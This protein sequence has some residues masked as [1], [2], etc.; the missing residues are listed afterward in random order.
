MRV[1]RRDT[2]EL[3]GGSWLLAVDSF[4]DIDTLAP[5]LALCRPNLLTSNTLIR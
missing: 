4:I 3:L 1:C 2:V 5:Y